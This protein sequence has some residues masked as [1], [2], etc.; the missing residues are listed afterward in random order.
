MPGENVA[1]LYF[2][3]GDLQYPF[4]IT[5]DSQ[6][7]QID[8]LSLLLGGCFNQP[9]AIGRT[10]TVVLAT[11]I[12]RMTDS[13]FVLKDSSGGSH[14]EFSLQV[15]TRECKLEQTGHFEVSSDSTY[16]VAKVTAPN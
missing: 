15:K 4:I 14:P 1:L 13:L 2:V 9:N 5:Y 7:S 10:T 16:H 11:H 3:V 6:G 8:S 12:I